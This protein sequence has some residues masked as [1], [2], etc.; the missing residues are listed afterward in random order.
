MAAL[1]AVETDFGCGGMCQVSNLYSFSEVSRGPP[2]Q[3]CSIALTEF[4]TEVSSTTKGWFWTFSSII[5]L[6]GAY[7]SFFWSKK[8]NKLESPLLGK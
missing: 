3:N 7:L 2:T 8:H 4:I 1:G 5:F 6:C